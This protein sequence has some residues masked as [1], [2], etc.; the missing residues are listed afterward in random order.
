MVLSKYRDWKLLMLVAA[1][2]LVARVAF[3]FT[4][5]PH[6]ACEDMNVDDWLRTAE[7][8][9]NGNGYTLVGPSIPTAKRGPVVVFFFAAILWLFGQHGLP[10]IIAQWIVD[11]ATCVLLY[12]LVLKIFESRRVALVS[13][14]LFA[15]YVP[16]M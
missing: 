1:I 8:L 16:E 15:C 10:I 4:Y 9:V 12:L 11:A 14:L 2:A 7:N 13:S 6:N 5:S 3:F